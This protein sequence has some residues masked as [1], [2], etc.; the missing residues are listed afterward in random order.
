MS[1]NKTRCN[2]KKSRCKNGNKS[3]NNITCKI[4]HKTR[5]KYGGTIENVNRNCF[6]IFGTPEH[7]QSG[8]SLCFWFN[9][10]PYITTRQFIDP[11]NNYLNNR[12]RKTRNPYKYE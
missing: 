8:L 3:R 12:K 4:V 9:F 11:M 2:S 1:N 10:I 5:K 6:F 7:G